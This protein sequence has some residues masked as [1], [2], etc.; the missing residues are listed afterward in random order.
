MWTFLCLL[1]PVAS[2]ILHRLRSRVVLN[3]KCLP[4]S[5]AKIIQKA[6]IPTSCDPVCLGHLGVWMED[7]REGWAGVSV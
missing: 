6:K 4:D 2:D 3:L 5:E 7:R 1:G